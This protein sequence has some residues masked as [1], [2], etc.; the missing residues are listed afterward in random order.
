MNPDFTRLENMFID[1]ISLSFIWRR[2]F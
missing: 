2:S 1:D